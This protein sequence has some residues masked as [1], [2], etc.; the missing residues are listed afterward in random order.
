MNLEMQGDL[1][2]DNDWYVYETAGGK[3]GDRYL[4]SSLPETYQKLLRQNSQVPILR[5][6]TINGKV[7]SCGVK[8]YIKPACGY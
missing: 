5:R 4:V 7:Y 1:F 8:G 3:T 6:R 2:M